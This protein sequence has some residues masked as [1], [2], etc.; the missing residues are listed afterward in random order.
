MASGLPAIGTGRRP[1]LGDATGDLG[2]EF[3]SDARMRAYRFLEV[4][5]ISAEVNSAPW[6]TQRNCCTRL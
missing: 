4:L 1:Y 2:A 3:D 6:R 5:L